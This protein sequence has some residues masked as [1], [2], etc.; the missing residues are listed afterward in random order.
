MAKGPP[1]P[2]PYP[3]VGDIL[4]EK[5]Q[6][7]YKIGAGSFGA[8]FEVQNV[9]DGKLYAV[10]LER[11]DIGTPQLLPEYKLYQL[12]DGAAAFPRVYDFWSEKNWK[13][14][15]MD[16]LGMSL[17]TNYR[18][19]GKILSL[20][21]TLMVA[22]HMV[23]RLEYLHQR[24]Y[25]HRD[26]KPDNFVFGVG[27]NSNTLYM[28]DLGLAKKYRDLKTFEQIPYGEDKGVTG[29]AR[30]VSIN[31]HLGVDQSCRDDLESV[32][33][34]L[35]S[36]V[37]GHL[38]WEN[39]EGAGERLEAISQSKMNTP[40]DVLCEGLPNEFFTF[41]EKVRG[42]RFDERPNYTYLRG[43]FINLMVKK[44]LAFDYQYDWVLAREKRIRD[45]LTGATDPRAVV[46]PVSKYMTEGVTGKQTNFMQPLPF[47]TCV[48]QA[49]RFRALSQANELLNAKTEENEEEVAANPLPV[50]AGVFLL[51]PKSVKLPVFPV[52]LE[53]EPVRPSFTPVVAETTP[54]A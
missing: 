51:S 44:N 47:F 31:V 46:I 54:A 26:I 45:I 15:I 12:V 35:I 33:Y 1:P 16:R 20:K 3:E 11:C 28:I 22:I 17:G 19:C 7:I 13:G 23:C 6:I 40:L 43:L 41:M 48:F 27:T 25:I 52:E 53:F 5:Y 30:Y 39:L 14:M 8:I 29:T 37:A 24:S 32:G 49:A 2:P 21:T 34:V 38:P 9:E 42:M 36:L 4:N 18:T 50:T 10:K